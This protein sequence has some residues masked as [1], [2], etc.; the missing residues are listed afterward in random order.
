MLPL[1]WTLMKVSE[2]PCDGSPNSFTNI[3]TITMNERPEWFA[4]I[5]IVQLRGMKGSSP[6]QFRAKGQQFW[7]MDRLQVYT[8]IKDFK[9]NFQS[10][11][12]WEEKDDVPIQ[13]LVELEA[14]WSMKCARLF[15]FFR[16]IVERFR[17]CQLIFPQ[18]SKTKW[19]NKFSNTETLL[20]Y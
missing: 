20:L 11:R 5:V 6:C 14:I 10:W 2:C 17:V 19:E 1:G 15:Y 7:V 13:Y 9:Q 8:K 16:W 4:V 3:S 18:I 12:T